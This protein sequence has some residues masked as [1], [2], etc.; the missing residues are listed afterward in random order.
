MIISYIAEGLAHQLSDTY[1][2]HARQQSSRAVPK[3]VTHHHR[4][5]LIVRRSH[6]GVTP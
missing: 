1:A 5:R 2:V 4:P 6:V 3:E